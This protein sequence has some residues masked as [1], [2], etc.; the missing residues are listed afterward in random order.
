MS[1]ETVDV[2]TEFNNDVSGVDLSDS[3]IDSFFEAKGEY[4]FNQSKEEKV[5]PKPEE[6]TE[7]KIE[8][9]VEKPED[10]ANSRFKSLE[11]Q[12]SK[13]VSAL[14]PSKKEEKEG[15]ELTYENF[16]LEFLKKE[17]ETL[18]ES[19]QKDQE[20]RTKTSEH[21]NVIATYRIG[22]EEFIKTAPDFKTAYEF[23]V[24]SRV[25][26]YELLGYS[27]NDAI[28]LANQDEFQVVKT[29]IDNK[30]NPA[31]V[32]YKL[33]EARGYKK[34]EEPQPDD[35]KVVDLKETVKKGQKQA[36]SLSSIGK[37][38]VEGGADSLEALAELDGEDFNKAW[39]KLFKKR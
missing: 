28:K 18:K 1:D 7:I 16:P 24:G 31:E 26:E 30:K 33:A 25:Q 11:D 38:P 17:L 23:A 2:A 37:G 10:S 20:D 22:A 32:L 39:D 9:K 35:K 29:A 6:K 15:E 4:D 27:K 8:S 21:N 34:S 36:K 12:I 14:H 3:V 19:R 13:L 5:E